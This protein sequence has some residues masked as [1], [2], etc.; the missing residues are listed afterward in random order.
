MNLTSTQRAAL[1]AYRK[2]LPQGEYTPPPP[3]LPASLANLEDRQLWQQY[4]VLLRATP[5][6][7]EK[8]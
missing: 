7:G 6:K 5:L 3:T 8:K 1:L 4:A 2:T